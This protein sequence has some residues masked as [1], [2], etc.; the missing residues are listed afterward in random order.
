MKNHSD[1]ILFV[2]LRDINDNSS[3]SISNLALVSGL[4]QLGHNVFLTVPNGIKPNNLKIYSNLHILNLGNNFFTKLNIFRKNKIIDWI[5]KVLRKLYYKF[6]I[7]D[8]SLYFLKNF[9]FSIFNSIY[10]DI[11]I[12][13]SDPKTS[14]LFVK[15]LIDLGIKY[16]KWVQ[17]WGDPLSEDISNS[18]FLPK[19][20]LRFIEY[21]I[22]FNSDK[23]V[24]VSPITYQ[25]QKNIFPALEKK[26]FFIPLPSLGQFSYPEITQQNNIKLGYFGD[27]NSKIRNIKPLYDFV[28]ENEDFKLIIAGSS[29]ISL[30]PKKNIIIHPRVGQQELYKL[31][32]ECD[33][34]IIISNSRG[35]QIPGKIYYYSGSNKNIIVLI[36]GEN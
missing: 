18:Y 21:K 29:N 11:V 1:N 14:H 31:E 27:Y 33:F 30:K 32:T 12:S 15:K 13:T 34:L 35:S 2:T 4:L 36:D 23:I 26:M 6:N 8:S 10:F 5:Y 7:Y 20:Y 24:Y 17:H 22:L 3:V 19:I 25:R 16:D 28:S 9:E